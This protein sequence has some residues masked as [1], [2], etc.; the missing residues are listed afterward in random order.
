VVPAEFIVVGHT[1]AAAMD[2]REG[3]APLWSNALAQAQALMLGK[4]ESEARADLVAAGADDAEAGRLAPHKTFPGDRPST[5]ILMDAL[6]P[7]ALGALLALYEHKTFVEGVIWD[8][9]SFD[10]WGV[11][12]GKVLA[13]AIFADVE[14]GEPSPGLDPSTS[15]L[16]K[17]LLV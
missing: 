11:E 6:T 10:Q 15:E 2:A 1:T 4:S 17:R 12:L 8:I 16:M 3:D 7:E 14:R 13:R 9:N 5:T